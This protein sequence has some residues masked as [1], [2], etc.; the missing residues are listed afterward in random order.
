M[1]ND[2]ELR[3]AELVENPTARVPVCLVL[4]VSSSMSVHGKIEELN[5][6]IQ[7]FF[8]AV[9]EDE[10]ASISAEISI[11]T[12]GSDAQQILDFA[13]IE[14]Q[15]VPQLVP[16][17]Y[18]A[19]GTGVNLALDLLDDVKRKYSEMGNDYYQPW[20]VLMTDGE[21]AGEPAEVTQSAITRCR[22]MVQ[23]RKLTVFP[24]AIGND[25]NLQFLAKFSPNL[26]PLRVQSTD[27]GRFFSWLAKSINV[28]T[29]SNP[30]D[31]QSADIGV[32]VFEKMST[33]FHSNIM[34]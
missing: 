13:N 33:D 1:R 12:F 4:D 19:M 20:L 15:K 21:P 14:R 30:G 28:V 24:I 9:R 6:G 34:K 11:V 23:K 18:T 32:S 3:Q 7:S 26:A 31:S 22:E 17:G 2:F 16:Y 25:A 29:M 5:R 27:F 8:R 10:M